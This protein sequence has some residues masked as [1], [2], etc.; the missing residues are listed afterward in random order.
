MNL[1]E[2][3]FN[4]SADVNDFI[5]NE[6]KQL[7]SN[8]ENNSEDEDNE[9]FN[10]KKS[11]EFQIVVDRKALENLIKTAGSEV[12]RKSKKYTGKWVLSIQ[13]RHQLIRK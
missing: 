3:D 8:T 11:T 6:F 7:N 10:A 4:F 13:T 9:D 2:M 1:T 5:N 12:K